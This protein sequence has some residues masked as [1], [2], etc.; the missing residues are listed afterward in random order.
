MEK[1]VFFSKQVTDSAKGL[2]LILLLWHHLFFDITSFGDFVQFTGKLAKVCVAI[3]LFLSGY[4]FFETVKVKEQSVFRFWQKRLIPLYLTFW[5]VASISIFLGAQ[6]FERSM[7]D[8]YG[9]HVWLKWVVQMS[10]FYEY[11]F[12]GHGYNATWWYMSA[13]IP[14]VLLFPLIYRAI[15]ISHWFV[16]FG[17]IVMLILHRH[18]FPVINDWI[19]PFTL[20]MIFSKKDWFESIVRFFRRFQWIR[21]FLYGILFSVVAWLR[22]ESPILSGQR[23]DW[24]FGAILLVVWTDFVTGWDTPR[25]L[26]SWLGTHLFHVFLTHSFLFYYFFHDWIY[27]FGH[28]IL[29]F[30]V[31]LA[32]S[33][34]LSVVLDLVKRALYFDRVQD[35]LI[36]LSNHL[37]PAKWW[38]KIIFNRGL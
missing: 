33:L 15:Q 21:L 17:L 30:M 32:T 12:S 26:F 31:L 20:G 25:K 3:F 8:G 13:I 28:P 22:T 6:F 11:I 24:L 38:N 29:I 5:L 1:S 36:Q 35:K 16:L 14:L 4:G 7:M 18:F 19:L 9:E 34:L 27:S 10:G 2:A 37:L 23:M